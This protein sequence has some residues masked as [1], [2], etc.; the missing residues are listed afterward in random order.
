[1]LTVFGR[2]IIQQILTIIDL[3]A[4]IGASFADS[5]TVLHHG[6]RPTVMVFLKQVYFTG[7]EALKVIIIISLIIGTVIITQ[8]ISVVGTGNESLTGKVLVWTVIKELG[9]LLTAI[10]VIARSG[11]AIATELGSM[12]INGEID[13]IETLGID[14]SH[15]LIAPRI[16]GVTTAV[17]ILTIYFE[18]AS[19]LGGFAVAGLGWHVPFEQF[20]QGVFASLTIKELVIATVKSLCFGLF[21]TAACCKQGL[22]VGKSATQIPQA[23]T[24]G[25]MM[26]L[27]LVF[28]LDGIITMI[29][30]V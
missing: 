7:L 17:V 15:Y 24:K 22:A 2:W 18:I 9:P 16:L 8:I 1:M 27:F 11:T 12:K 4:L 3:A 10:I 29:S 5:L 26:S 14:P 13:Y 23:A 30:F 28:V 19:I 25:V 6:R 20:S 21:M